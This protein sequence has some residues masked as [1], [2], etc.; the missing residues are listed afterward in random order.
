MHRIVQSYVCFCLDYISKG[1]VGVT[2]VVLSMCSTLQCYRQFLATAKASLHGT[3]TY[4]V[5][6]LSML[7]RCVTVS[8]CQ[9]TSPV[10]TE[11]VSL[12]AALERKLS[13]ILT[14]IFTVPSFC[15]Q[16]LLTFIL[17]SS[18]IWSCLTLMLPP[19]QFHCRFLQISPDFGLQTL[20]YSKRSD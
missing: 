4:T 5:L 10:L 7:L 19:S 11:S 3:F 6:P 20:C 18:C 2:Q 8:F 13:D 16:S 17:S 1:S 12:K 14:S 15:I 9:K